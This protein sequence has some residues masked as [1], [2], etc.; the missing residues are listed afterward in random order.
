[1]FCHLS[2]DNAATFSLEIFFHTPF[3]DI[4]FFSFQNLWYS[5]SGSNSC[6]YIGEA[7]ISGHCG[8]SL[9]TMKLCV[10]IIA[11]I[12]GLLN[13]EYFVAVYMGEKTDLD[14]SYECSSIS[15]QDG[16]MYSVYSYNI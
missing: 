2:G 16:N 7:I 11:S 9:M 6:R 5:M 3:N 12:V 1:M 4:T 13:C 14:C 8:A 15:N 10:I